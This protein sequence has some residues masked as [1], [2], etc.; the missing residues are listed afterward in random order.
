MLRNGL[1]TR[2][3]GYQ[4]TIL[5]TLA[6]TA[7]LLL[8]F[9][10]LAGE[11]AEG[12]TLAFDRHILLALR[13]AADPDQPLGPWWLQ[14]AAQDLT[15]LG[16]IT[17]LTLITLAALGFLMLTGKRGAALLVLVSVGGGLALSSVLKLLFA[18]PRPDLVPHGDVVLTASFPSGHS[19]LS[20]IVY[21]TLGALLARFVARRRLKAYLLVLAVLL[22]LVIGSSRVYLGVHWPTDVLAGWSVGA[23][24]AAICWLVAQWLQSR[25]TVERD[26]QGDAGPVGDVPPRLS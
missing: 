19:M 13:S 6:V 20:A 16:S 3:S 5:L 2:L 15:A 9:V 24:W 22:T 17:I 21:L 8:G 4:L 10:E 11:V 26:T 18:R 14:R 25:G 23:S 7:A 1:W 12:E